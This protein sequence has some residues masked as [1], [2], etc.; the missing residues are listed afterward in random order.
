ML[1]ADMVTSG[2]LIQ[3]VTVVDRDG[4]I[5]ERTGDELSFSYRRKQSGRCSCSLSVTFQLK[6]DPSDE[7]TRR[8]R[9]KL[10]YEASHS[11]ACRSIS[12]LYFS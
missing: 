6:A 2:E 7:L 5:V 4:N 9:K 12:R 10:D 3:S 8:M 1:V 11:A